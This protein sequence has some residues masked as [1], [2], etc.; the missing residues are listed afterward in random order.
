M[1]FHLQSQKENGEEFPPNTLHHI[2]C[3]IQH[4][5]RMNVNSTIDFFK[6]SDF[7]DFHVCLDSEMK[8]LQR[9]G[10]E[11]KIRKAEPL[12][13]E[14]QELLWKKG[15]LGKGSPQTLVNTMLVMNEIY[16]ALGSGSEHRQL[17]AD[18]CQI[19]LHERPG[20]RSYLE[21]VEDISKTDLV[22]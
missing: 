19:T 5:V 10:H 7:A 22:G 21:Y 14:E 17:R 13:A 16:F 20:Q 15:L 8:R 6:D 3:G 4:H 18:P 9:A 12:T 1:Q 11:S 2:V